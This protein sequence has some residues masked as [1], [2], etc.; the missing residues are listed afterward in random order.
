MRS[1]AA[2]SADIRQRSL[3]TRAGLPTAARPRSAAPAAV[4]AAATWSVLAPAPRRGSSAHAPAAAAR[5]RA[6]LRTV[7]MQAGGR[8]PAPLGQQQQQPA[9]PAAAALA[10]RSAYLPVPNQP[11]F[12]DLSQVRG[13]LRSVWRDAGG[14]DAWATAAEPPNTTRPDRPPPPSPIHPTPAPP[15]VLNKQ[16]ITRTSGRALG[17]LCACWMDPSRREVV[18]FD[19]DD[20]RAASSGAG[21]AASGLSRAVAGAQR[22][23]NLPLAALRQIGDVVL[24]HDE[25]GLYEQDLDGRLGFVSPVGM[26][27]RT[28]AGDFL[29]KV[30]AAAVW[31][32]DWGAAF[33]VWQGRRGGL[34]GDNPPLT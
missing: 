12:L 7:C 30:G 23:G 8:Q 14:L 33:D 19:L 13:W 28:A 32:C 2:Q 16:V 24:V 4:A 25:Q 31:G 21:A 29:G 17:S 10:P 11:V 9:A 15:Q 20:R 27:V 18:S 26:E 1:R 6:T 5:G 22:V 3:T 34:C